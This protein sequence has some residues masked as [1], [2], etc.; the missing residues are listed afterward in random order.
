[1][2]NDEREKTVKRLARYLHDV[3]DGERPDCEEEQF[4]N[5]EARRIIFSLEKLFLNNLER[6]CQEFIESDQSIYAFKKSIIDAMQN[7]IPKDETK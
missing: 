4:F 1:M 3:F 5:N 2:T 7:S 6:V